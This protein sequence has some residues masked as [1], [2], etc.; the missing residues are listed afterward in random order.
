MNAVMAFCNSTCTVGLD[1]NNGFSTTCCQTDNC[2]VDAAP[3]VTNANV[4]SCWVDYF[5]IFLKNLI[6]WFL[7]KFTKAGG[8]MPDGSSQIIAKQSCTSPSNKYCAVIIKL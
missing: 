5:N 2:N 1:P 6:S 7:K 4:S 8:E 3:V